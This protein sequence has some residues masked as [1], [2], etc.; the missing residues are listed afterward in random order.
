MMRAGLK[1]DIGRCAAGKRAGLFQRQDLGMRP[2]ADLGPTAPDNPVI[3][4][5]D[6]TDSGVRPGLAKAALTKRQGQLHEP[7]VSLEK[8]SHAH[9]SAAP[10]GRSSETN[11]SKSSAAWKFL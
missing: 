3:L 11:L 1:A 8:F 9:S 7:A 6:G 10:C 2:A 5:D 4:D